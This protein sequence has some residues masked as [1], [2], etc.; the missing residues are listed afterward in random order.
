M[1]AKR[2]II[3]FIYDFDGTLSPGNMQEYDYIPQLGIKPKQFWAE[4]RAKAQKN[5]ADEIIVYMFEMLQRARGKVPIRKE[6]FKSYGKQVD[7]FHGVKE[8]FARINTYTRKFNLNPEHYIISSGIKE[9]IAGTEIACEFREIFASSFIY[10]QHGVAESPGLAINYTTKTQFLFRIN[11]GAMDIT[12]NKTINEFKEDT[13]RPIPFKNMIFLGD[14]DTDI[15]CMKLVKAQGGHSIA[16]YQPRKK[17]K[18]AK[19]KKLLD[20]KRV[21]YIAPADYSAGGSLEIYV[22][23]VVE[24]VAADCKIAKLTK[25]L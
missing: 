23:A 7:F 25:A 5:Q 16:V 18:K 13:E 20:D 17:D 14:G 19:A 2:P 24:K 11:K 15:P 4:V 21:N 8:W 6:D 22:Q 9:M 10:E 12:D 3:A 1:S